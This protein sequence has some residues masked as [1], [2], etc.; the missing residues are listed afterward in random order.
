VSHPPIVPDVIIVK[1]AADGTIAEIIEQ[2]A[3]GSRRTA[4]RILFASGC[5]LFV[6][7]WLSY[8][9]HGSGPDSMV[10]LKVDLLAV[11]LLLLVGFL[12][13]PGILPYAQVSDRNGINFYHYPSLGQIP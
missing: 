12:S 5:F 9:G 8:L 7:P 4:M 2:G 13:H 3:Y 11:F 10:A 1:C 6:Y